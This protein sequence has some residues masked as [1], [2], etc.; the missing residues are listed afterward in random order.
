MKV[1]TQQQYYCILSFIQPECTNYFKRKKKMKTQF[2]IQINQASYKIF[3]CSD[4]KR[5]LLGASNSTTFML[6][7]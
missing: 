4:L 1:D 3:N 6:G 5:V 7:A 2:Q